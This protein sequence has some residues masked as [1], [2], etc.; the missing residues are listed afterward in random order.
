VIP[1]CTNSAAFQEKHPRIY[2]F[3][4]QLIITIV[5]FYCAIVISRYSPKRDLIPVL[6]IPGIIAPQTLL[7]DT[8]SITP[9]IYKNNARED[10]VD[11]GTTLIV[12]SS[13]IFSLSPFILPHRSE[14]HTSS[15]ECR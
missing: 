4:C 8:N 10:I 13:F 7:N 15:P 12:S 1:R 3:L 5:T 9:Y 6:A 2:I 11:L 14:K